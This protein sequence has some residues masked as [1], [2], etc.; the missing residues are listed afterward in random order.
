MMKVLFFS[1][2]TAAVEEIAL[3]LRLRWPDLEPM[4]VAQG[5]KG[6]HVIEQHDNNRLFRPRVIYEGTRGLTPP[7]HP[8]S[9]C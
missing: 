6:L 4:A 7:D 9:P 1:K 3:A 5:S 2:D 8:I